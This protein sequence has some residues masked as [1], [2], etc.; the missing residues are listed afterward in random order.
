MSIVTQKE[1]EDYY[2]TYKKAPNITLTKNIVECIGLQMKQC[3]L[4][5]KSEYYP[6]IVYACCLH[7]AK[8][9]MNCPKRLLEDITEH[10][11]QVFLRLYFLSKG[12]A[13]PIAFLIPAN[14]VEFKEIQKGNTL[15]FDLLLQFNNRPPDDLIILLGGL[16]EAKKCYECRKDER[17]EIDPL[18]LKRVG[19]K[20]KFTV[21]KAQ[22]MAIKCILKDL[23]FSGAQVILPKN[24]GV[25][26]HDPCSIELDF[27]Q[28]E[29][30]VV[31]EGQVVGLNDLSVAV[32]NAVHIKFTEDKIPINF[33]IYIKDY[34]NK[35]RFYLQESPSNNR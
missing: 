5:H 4:K 22:T 11:T 25:K 13:H 35:K 2:N 8:I 20:S 26:M 10:K 19:L 18:T 16:L 27:D 15:F 6:C 33:K 17:I 34:L 23:S 24:A 31:N 29:L 30:P 9:F 28:E 14:I 3:Y 12:T 7:Q 32:L 21:F 1:I